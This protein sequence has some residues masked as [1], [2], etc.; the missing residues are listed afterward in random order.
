[1][2]GAAVIAALPPPTAPPA[3]P[4]GAGEPEATPLTVS[5]D[6]NACFGWE[7]QRKAGLIRTFCNTLCDAQ[8]RA[9][10]NAYA[11]GKIR[12]MGRLLRVF[13]S[14][15]SPYRLCGRRDARRRA[16]VADLVVAE[17]S[18]GIIC[19]APPKCGDPWKWR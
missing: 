2:S 5:P 6:S 13:T 1:M 4:V 16:E 3:G 15:R 10:R 19:G 8:R 11:R 18:T 17:D 9:G 14:K 7:V 12:Q